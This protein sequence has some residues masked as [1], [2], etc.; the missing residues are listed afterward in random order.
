MVQIRANKAKLYKAQGSLT[1][2]QT[3]MTVSV[4]LSFCDFGFFL[5]FFKKKKT[6]CFFVLSMI[7]S[8]HQQMFQCLKQWEQVQKV[9]FCCLNEKN[10]N[11]MM[12]LGKNENQN[13]RKSEFFFKKNN[14]FFCSSDGWHE[15]SYAA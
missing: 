15:Q 5:H 14:F 11:W 12:F 4:D 13:K 3:E 2:A 10:S 8:M 9:C 7:D 1:S 6:I